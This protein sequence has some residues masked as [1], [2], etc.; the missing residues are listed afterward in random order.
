MREKNYSI[1]PVSYSSHQITVVHTGS[2]LLI[3]STNGSP[4]WRHMMQ[5]RMA[6]ITDSCWSAGDMVL[7][8]CSAGGAMSFFRFD[9]PN[10]QKRELRLFSESVAPNC[11][12]TS[13]YMNTDSS[14]V[15]LLG[16]EAAGTP[17]LLLRPLL[18]L[19]PTAALPVCPSATT[20]TFAA[21]VDRVFYIGKIDCE[22]NSRLL[23]LPSTS[24]ARWRQPASV[25][26]ALRVRRDEPRN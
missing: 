13:L 25:H 4:D 7:V 20:V 24:A 12:C 26:C 16:N 18:S 15:Y 1:V 17:Q 19:P 22:L 10:A 6:R 14:T 23:A 9:R 11:S 8:T 5:D 2:A 21:P 3:F